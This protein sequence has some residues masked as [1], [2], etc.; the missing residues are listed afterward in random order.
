MN[1]FEKTPHN[2]VLGKTKQK[3]TN[4]KRERERERNAQSHQY[5]T[6]QSVLTASPT[7]SV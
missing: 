3:Q 6:S 4:K 5:L 2:D 7:A 1:V